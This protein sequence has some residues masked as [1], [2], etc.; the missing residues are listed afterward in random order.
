MNF[1]IG[2]WNRLAFGIDI[3]VPDWVPGHRRPGVRG[4]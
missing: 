1:V 4:G 3:R 2:A